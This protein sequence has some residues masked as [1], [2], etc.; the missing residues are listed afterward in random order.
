MFYLSV[1]LVTCKKIQAHLL[2]VG[3]TTLSLPPQ[4]G[5]AFTLLCKR[6]VPGSGQDHR[7]ISADQGQDRLQGL[8][9][10][11]GYRRHCALGLFADG[12]EAGRA[13]ARAGAGTVGD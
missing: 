6:L 11:I 4:G 3:Y 2:S 1:L 10:R 9:Y 13:V 7:D 8:C 12:I 5:A